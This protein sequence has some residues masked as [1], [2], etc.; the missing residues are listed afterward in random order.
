M[1]AIAALV[2]IAGN[3]PSLGQQL[4]G[5]GEKPGQRIEVRDLKR[6]EGGTITL[7]FQFLNEGDDEISSCSFKDS[8]DSC[9]VVGGVHLIDAANKKKYLVVR[10]AQKKCVCSNGVDSIRKGGRSNA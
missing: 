10:D 5:D 9:G 3:G 7:R 6:D 8:M 1:A 4:S 2:F